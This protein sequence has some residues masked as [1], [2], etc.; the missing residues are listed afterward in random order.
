ML[1]GSVAPNTLNHGFDTLFKVADL[2]KDGNIT[3][4]VK[5]TPKKF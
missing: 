2:N 1:G 3:R 5:L 4:Q